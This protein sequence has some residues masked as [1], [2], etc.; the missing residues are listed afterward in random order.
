MLAQVYFTNFGQGLLS[1]LKVGVFE[2]M[3]KPNLWSKYGGEAPQASS[4]L[5]NGEGIYPSPAATV[6]MGERRE[7]PLQFS[8]RVCQQCRVVIAD[9]MSSHRIFAAFNLHVTTHFWPHTVIRPPPLVKCVLFIKTHLT[10]CCSGPT[11]TY[12]GAY[13]VA[14]DHL[15]RLGRPR[16]A[17]QEG[18]NGMK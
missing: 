4:G 2:T 10:E 11:R 17:D 15:A 8:F 9:Y 14:L 12:W 16:K 3:P 18:I 5:G 6:G 13:N 1:P 7:Q